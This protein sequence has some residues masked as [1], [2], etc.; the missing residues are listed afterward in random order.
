MLHVYLESGRIS[1][2][3]IIWF[4]ITTWLRLDGAQLDKYNSKK[5]LSAD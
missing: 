3:I 5:E 1:I 2:L 4:W